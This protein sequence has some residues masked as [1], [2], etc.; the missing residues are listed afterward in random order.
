VACEKIYERVLIACKRIEE[1]KCYSFLNPLDI[2]I[3]FKRIDDATAAKL[4][5]INGKRFIQNDAYTRIGRV[6][7]IEEI[8]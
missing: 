8:F 7:S 5:D 6:A 2:E 3:R 1:M 4:Y